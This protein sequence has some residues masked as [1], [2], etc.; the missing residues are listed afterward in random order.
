MK[1]PSTVTFIVLGALC[2]FTRSTTMLAVVFFVGGNAVLY[3]L[4]GFQALSQ[5]FFGALSGF[6]TFYLVKSLGRLKT[7]AGLA[8]TDQTAPATS[9]PPPM[10]TPPSSG[11]G[12]AS[13]TGG[14]RGDGSGGGR[15][16]RPLIETK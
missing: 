1:K 11:R 9:T 3:A 2:A 13:G 16:V 7:A 15:N 14:G 6:V 5:I 4:V 12:S 10:V 8:S